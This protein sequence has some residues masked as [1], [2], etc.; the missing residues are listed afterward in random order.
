MTHEEE[1]ALVRELG[2]L[3]RVTTLCDKSEENRKRGERIK[4]IKEI[5]G[6]VSTPKKN[7]RPSRIVWR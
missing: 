1:M 7:K 3:Q 2:E 5:L 6:L 4:E